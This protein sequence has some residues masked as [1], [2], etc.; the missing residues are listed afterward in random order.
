MHLTQHCQRIPPWPACVLQPSLFIVSL[1]RT[2]VIVR[3]LV[4]KCSTSHLSVLTWVRSGWY[5]RFLKKLI[6]CIPRDFLSPFC[7]CQLK[8][9][10]FANIIFSEG[11]TSTVILKKKKTH[12][13]QIKPFFTLGKW[14]MGNIFASKLLCFGGSLI[15]FPI[16]SLLWIYLQWGHISRSWLH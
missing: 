14:S 7:P 11:H 3:L 8:H 12:T 9:Y 15:A 13:H 4:S 5:I 6:R 10:M 16:T 1:L 2:S